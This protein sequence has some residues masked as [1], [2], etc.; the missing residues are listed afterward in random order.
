MEQPKKKIIKNDD[1]FFQYLQD[2][3]APTIQAT[4]RRKLATKK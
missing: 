1:V 2:E 4:I 3:A